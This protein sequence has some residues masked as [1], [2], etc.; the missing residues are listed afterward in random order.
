MWDYPMSGT[1]LY[2]SDLF[3]KHQINFPQKIG[4]RR[5][6]NQSTEG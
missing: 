6:N 4:Q 3:H 5:K 2:D 1:S